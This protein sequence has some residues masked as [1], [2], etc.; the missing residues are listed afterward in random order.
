MSDHATDI[1]PQTM[2]HLLRRSAERHP[3]AEIVFPDERSTFAEVDARADAYR[4]M[5]DHA[6]VRPGENVGVWLPA[7]LESIAALFGTFRAGAV[8]V[9]INDRYRPDEIG[10][11]IANA[12]VVV[13]LIGQPT[14]PLDRA[15]DLLTAFPDLEDQT[16]ELA[17][18]GAPRLRRVVQVG[19]GAG[20]SWI[21]PATSLGLDDPNSA[22]VQL[23]IPEAEPTELAYLMFTSGTSAAPKAC[24][25]T[26]RGCLL[27]ADSL[28]FHRYLLD[29][30]SAFWCPLPLFHTAGLATLGACIASGANFIHA[31]AFDPAQSLRTLEFE[32][33]THAVPAFETIWMRVLDHP[34]FINSD[35]SR[36]RVV[37]MTGGPD[38]LRKLQ[39]RLPWVTQVTNFGLTEATGHLAMNRLDDPLEVRLTTGGEPL[40]GMEVR[41]VDPLTSEPCA[42][43]VRGEIQFRG[44]SRCVGYYGDAA[45]TEAAIDAEG[46]FHS[47]D[48]GELDQEGRLTFKGRLKDMLKVGGENVAALEVESYLSRHP[49]VNVVAVVGAPDAYYGE[50]PVAYIELAPGTSLTEAEVI[51]YCLDAIATYKVPRYVRFVDAWPMSGTKIKKF[52]LREGIATELAD[53]G[54]TQAPRL[55]SKRSMANPD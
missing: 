10:Y 37:L 39:S 19:E 49:S 38:Q 6:G 23:V 35:L 45:A 48:L 36:L 24:M 33:V 42:P 40:P 20:E 9:P 12:D 53:A 8:A 30:A 27:Q 16:S 22:A 55:A 51:D 44:P 47:G 11:V 13:L 41:I 2:A 46:W 17:L 32:S 34:D 43:S 18:S 25:I 1:I 7:G 31:G 5:L 29:E 21:V 28:A 14:G 3:T 52:V 4:T 26:H 54:I 15:A 50:V